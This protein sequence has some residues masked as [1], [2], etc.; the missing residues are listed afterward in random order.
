MSSA[1]RR[2]GTLDEGAL[3]AAVHWGTPPLMRWERELVL[4]KKAQENCGK[5]KGR[6]AWEAERGESFSL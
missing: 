1:G 2:A 3:P 5:N 4:M 6:Q